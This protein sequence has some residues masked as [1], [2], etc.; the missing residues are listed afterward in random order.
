MMTVYH[1]TNK[2]GLD[3]IRKDGH[4]LQSNRTHGDAVNG[5]GIIGLSEPN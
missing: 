1:Y 2:K 4:I 3:A 5:N